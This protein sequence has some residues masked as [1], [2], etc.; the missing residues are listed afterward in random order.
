MTKEKNNEEKYQ[1]LF[2]GFD[3]A[4]LCEF[5]MD[6]DWPPCKGTQNQTWW[7][8]PPGETDERVGRG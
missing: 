5:P 1:I 4:K 3:P 2:P 8:V 6:Q 7:A